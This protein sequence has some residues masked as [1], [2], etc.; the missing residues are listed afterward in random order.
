M[1]VSRKSTDCYKKKEMALVYR[2][3]NPSQSHLPSVE[4]YKRRWVLTLNRDLLSYMHRTSSFLAGVPIEHGQANVTHRKH[5]ALAVHC[6]SQ[7]PEP[8]HS[9]L[10]RDKVGYETR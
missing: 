10:Q 8:G 1:S 9:C 4:K 5:S 3:K 6:P 7:Q 2:G